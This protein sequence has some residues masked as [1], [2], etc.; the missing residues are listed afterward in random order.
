MIEKSS[1]QDELWR[2]AASLFDAHTGSW[3]TVNPHTIANIRDQFC[4]AVA[5]GN[6]ASLERIAA[7]WWPELPGELTKLQR[8]YRSAR[9]ENQETES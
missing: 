3:H 7:R 6:E 2:A 4:A 9:G 1:H 5:V 8:L